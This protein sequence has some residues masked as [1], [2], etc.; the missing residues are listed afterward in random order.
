MLV[1]HWCIDISQCILNLF[2]THSKSFPG[3]YDN[4]P[5]EQTAIKIWIIHT[6]LRYEGLNWSTSL[7]SI[8]FLVI[9]LVVQGSSILW[10]KS[11]Y[12]GQVPVLWFLTFPPPTSTSPYSFYLL[13]TSCHTWVHKIK[14]WTQNKHVVGWE[15]RSLCARGDYQAQPLKGIWFLLCPKPAAPPPD[16]APHFLPQVNGI[17]VLKSNL[18]FFRVS[19]LDGKITGGGLS[20]L[21][22][23]CVSGLIVWLVFVF[24]NQIF[25]LVLAGAHFNKM[26]TSCCDLNL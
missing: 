16:S 10:T 25:V 26:S 13:L 17:N 1:F 7:R 6:W 12:R 2:L 23:S 19:F 21:K 11:S 4:M 5:P 14:L 8:F 9:V 22:V 24:V 3:S 15:K 20:P 18:V